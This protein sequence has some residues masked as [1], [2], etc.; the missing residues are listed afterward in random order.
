[1][2]P[3][4]KPKKCKKCKAVFVPAVE[5]QKFCGDRCRDGAKRKRKAALVRQAR[6]II[7][8]QEK[9]SQEKAA[10]GQ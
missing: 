10:V 6:K 3:V 5:H 7:A 8:A 4:L 1:M 9:A 2:F